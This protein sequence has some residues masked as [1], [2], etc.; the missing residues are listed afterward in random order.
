[1]ILNGGESNEGIRKVING[2]SGDISRFGMMTQ[3]KNNKTDLLVP[4]PAMASKHLTRSKEEGLI[5]VHR[6][7]G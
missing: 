7:R 3:D 1:M 2:K 6:L 4:S 5:W